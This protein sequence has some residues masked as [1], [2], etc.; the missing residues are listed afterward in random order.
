MA[1]PWT[2]FTSETSTSDGHT[3]GE[4]GGAYATGW[5]VDPRTGSAKGL[6]GRARGYESEGK[7]QDETSWGGY[8]T[9][10][11][12]DE[13]GNFYSVPMESGRQEDVNRYQGMA[14]AA[15]ARDAYQN[16]YGMANGYN[17][18]ANR[19][20]A[21]QGDAAA[22]Y[23]QQALGQGSQAQALGQGMLRQGI[24]AQQ[25]AA[26]STRGGSLAQMAAM[27][28]QAQGAG[29]FMQA[30]GAQ[31]DALRAQEMAA[32]RLGYMNATGAQRAGDLTSQG[33]NQQQSLAQMQNELYQR[34]LNQKA[35]QGYEGMA[36]DVNRQAQNANLTNQEIDSG[37][38]NTIA[39]IN[40]ADKARDMRLAGAGV[41][42][43]A[44]MGTGAIR[45]YGTGNR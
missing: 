34:E 45:A 31:L 16:N 17:D 8:G 42:A 12:R 29:A 20:G 39:G 11:H 1:D 7:V 2:S 30:G 40:A 32:G 23:R 25:A 44:T 18:A 43:V 4:R 35:Q 24:A 27:R 41:S 19:M 28:Q 37:V 6:S 26:M 13:N 22:L 9:T 15:A 36:F 10:V 3:R 14:A 33:Q 38:A 21:Y 5:T